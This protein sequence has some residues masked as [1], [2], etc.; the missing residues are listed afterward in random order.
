MNFI[1]EDSNFI[2]ERIETVNYEFYQSLKKKYPSLTK[3]EID[4]IFKIKTGL[5]IK[6][7]S[8]ILNIAPNSVI[9]KR[10]RLRKK[11]A[12]NEDL[13]NFIHSLN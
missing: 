11:L 2:P 4:L 8:Q 9:V 3:S 1:Q 5:S 10:Y 7:I 12:I 6:Q 13:D